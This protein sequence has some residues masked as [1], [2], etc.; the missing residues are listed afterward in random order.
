MQEPE[1]PTPFERNEKLR[2]VLIVAAAY[3]V[4]A[5]LYK[6]LFHEGLGHTSLL[7]IGLPGVLA[8][9]LALAPRAGTAKGGIIKGITLALLLVAPLVGEG[10][11][12]ILM[13][14]PLF[15]AIGLAIGAGID[16]SRNSKTTT[17]SCT[18]VMVILL[19]L[20]GIL[21]T[22]PRQET[23]SVTRIIAA[24]A[25]EIQS[26]LAQPPDIATP[27]PR[28]LRL[29]FPRPIA[30]SGSGLAPGAT[31]TIHF[32]GAEG[33]PPGDLTLRVAYTND[34]NVLFLATRDTSKLT[35]WICW[36][37]SNVHWQSV[38]A[39]HTRVT[40]QTTFRRQLDPW[41]YFAPWERY[42]V[43]KSTEYLLTANATPTAHRA[44][45]GR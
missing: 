30:A 21:P 28:F 45:G 43:R 22:H 15:Y 42:A 25:A 33:D 18:A 19:S 23:V 41:W 17:L 12:C 32:T 35:Q 13:A 9:L 20:D 6:L 29:G 2:N 4:S 39:T 7:F 34:G 5:L 26:A 27:L 10:Y 16:A 44:S 3:I 37:S 8:I 1:Q 31:R 38:D 14:A 24:P 36:Q 11:L 40:W